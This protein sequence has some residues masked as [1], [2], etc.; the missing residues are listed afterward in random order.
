M[1]KITLTS[2]ILVELQLWPEEIEH[3]D[4]RSDIENDNLCPGFDL[5]FAGEVGNDQSMDLTW[6]IDVANDIG[7]IESYLYTSEYEYNRDVDLL[8]RTTKEWQVK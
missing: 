6:A 7:E 5:I 8:I 1:N 2:E 3:L 4:L